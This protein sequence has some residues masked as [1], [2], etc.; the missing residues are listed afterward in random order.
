MLS[1]YQG[2]AT[3]IPI[4]FVS[5]VYYK[6]GSRKQGKQEERH[7]TVVP[8]LGRL[9]LPLNSVTRSMVPLSASVSSEYFI[10]SV[11]EGENLKIVPLAS[12]PHLSELSLSQTLVLPEIRCDSAAT[13]WPRNLPRLS[14]IIRACEQDNFPGKELQAGKH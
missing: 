8:G 12:G 13:G 3:P 1:R 10:A 5:I 14:P 11:A 7:C 6:L 2:M 4:V 9:S